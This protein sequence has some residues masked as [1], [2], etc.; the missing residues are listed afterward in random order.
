MFTSKVYMYPIK[1][2]KAAERGWE[3]TSIDL[4]GPLPS[5][6]Y[7]VVI[8]NLTSCYPIAKLVKSTNVKSVIPVVEDIYDTFGN[9]I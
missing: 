6:N 5:K 7:T 4:I 8:Q 3:K 1:P 2:S 9:S